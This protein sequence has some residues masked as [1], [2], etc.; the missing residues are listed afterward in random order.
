MFIAGV[1]VAMMTGISVVQG[2]LTYVFLLFPAGIILLLFS[3]L[4]LLLFGF[5]GDYYLTSN[6]ERLSPLTYISLIDER[7]IK[8]GEL[9]IYLAV[10][11]L[12]YLLALYFYKKKKRKEH[13]K[14]LPFQNC[15]PFLNTV[16]P[17]ALCFLVECISVLVQSNSVG[18]MIFGYVIGAVIGYYLA[19]IVCKKHG[20]C[21]ETLKEFSFMVLSLR[22]VSLEPKHSV[23]M[24]IT[25]RNKMK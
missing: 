4:S 23:F 15:V 20:E 14:P 2:V 11:I 25:F 10:T 21:L 5:P 8:D 7:N 24:K 1:F 17:F 12:L 3:N 13:Q 6:L 9:I 16:S 22:Y 18:W 19:E